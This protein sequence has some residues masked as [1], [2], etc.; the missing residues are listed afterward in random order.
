MLGSFLLMRGRPQ[1][2]TV[3]CNSKTP[4]NVARTRKRSFLCRAR[5]YSFQYLTITSAKLWIR[6]FVSFN[7]DSKLEYPAP[8]EPPSPC[9]A[10]TFKTPPRR[11]IDGVILL[12][13]LLLRYRHPVMRIERSIVYPNQT[14]FCRKMQNQTIAAPPQT[15]RISQV[16]T[17]RIAKYPLFMPPAMHTILSQIAKTNSLNVTTTLHRLRAFVR[18]SNQPVHIQ[19]YI[20]SDMFPR[21]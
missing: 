11:L 19:K 9:W 20:N 10:Q 12:N 21:L 1:I 3:K 4:P 7:M 17:D 5:K 6:G 14:T 15:W 8:G 13:F 16:L 2:F 18:S